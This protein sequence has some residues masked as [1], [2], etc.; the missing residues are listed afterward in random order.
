LYDSLTPQG[1]Y[2]Q[3]F[4]GPQITEFGNAVNLAQNPGN[5]ALGKVTV[6]MVN[7]VPTVAFTTSMTFTIYNLGTGGTVGS[8]LATDTENV[9]VPITP[10]NA[11]GR[12]LF[13]ATFDFSSQDVVLPSTVAYGIKLNQLATDCATTPA[14]CGN[15]PNPIGS[16]NVLLSANVSAG[17]NVYPGYIFA[18]SL[19]ADVAGAALASDFGA[20][21]GAPT[22]VLTTFQG[23]PVGCSAGYGSDFESNAVSTY[24]GVDTIPA[25]EFSTVG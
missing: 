1:L 6:A 3:A 17:S 20:C 11:H 8:V 9:N 18:S 13:N 15:N 16:V 7:Y 24:L 25:V 5:A 12:A 10:L 23:V 22:G 14:D 4:N 2:S 21:P 19:Q